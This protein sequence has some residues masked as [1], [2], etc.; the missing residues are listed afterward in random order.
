VREMPP[1]P[2]IATF[3]CL[4]TRLLLIDFGLCH[5]K[6]KRCMAAAPCC[7]PTVSIADIAATC[8]WVLEMDETDKCNEWQGSGQ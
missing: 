4:L 1:V 6:N 7:E 2:I 3:R 8:Q 5:G